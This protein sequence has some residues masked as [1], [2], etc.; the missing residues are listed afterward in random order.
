M[1]LVVFRDVFFGYLDSLADFGANDLLREQAVA[2]VAFV[3]LPV[4]ALGGHGLFQCL[5]TVE[6][7]LNANQVEALDDVSFDAHPHVFCALHEK[8]LVNEIAEG[9][10]LLFGD[11]SLN[12][13]LGTFRAF[14]GDFLDGLPAGVLVFSA[15]DDLIVDASDDLL[16]GLA[17]VLSQGRGRQK[18][19]QECKFL[20]CAPL[21]V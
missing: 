17:L 3:L 19:Q 20:H 21:R 7:V 16:D 5:H 9:V 12:L 15:R 4:D 14:L 8:G 2:D 18:R 6:L 11:S 13:F 1:F 10:L